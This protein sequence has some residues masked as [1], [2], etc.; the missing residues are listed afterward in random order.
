MRAQALQAGDGQRLAD[1][2]HG[3]EKRRGDSAAGHGH[4][5]RAEGQARLVSA[6]LNQR[7]VEQLVQGI[8][9]PIGLIH[10]LQRGDG[11]VQH[12]SGGILVL[13]LGVIRRLQIF[14]GG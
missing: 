10:T 4:T 9:L 7:L 1:D 8:G 11:G 2:L 12:F 14:L 3:L 6:V 5:D 13:L